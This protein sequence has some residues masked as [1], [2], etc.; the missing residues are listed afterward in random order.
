MA[1]TPPAAAWM[2]ARCAAASGSMAARKIYENIELIYS[3]IEP[4]ENL[5]RAAFLNSFTQYR[6]L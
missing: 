1:I 5:F 6:A 4:N 3:N 2:R